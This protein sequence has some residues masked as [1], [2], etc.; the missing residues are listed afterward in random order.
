MV[1]HGS[2]LFT[3]VLFS[4]LSL[5]VVKALEVSDL[6]ETDLILQ[7]ITASIN[8][9]WST[10]INDEVWMCEEPCNATWEPVDGSL[11]Q[12]DA[13]DTEVWGID[14]GDTVYKAPIDGSAN[15]TLVPGEMKHI[16]AS[17]YGYI[18]AVGSGDLVHKCKKPCNGEWDTVE[19]GPQLRQL[20]GEYGLVYGVTRSGEVYSRPVDGSGSWRKIPGPNG[21]MM[22]Y[23][24]ASGREVI[25]GITEGGHIYRCIKPCVGEWEK[26]EGSAQQCDASVNDVYC[27]NL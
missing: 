19:D 27:I 9:L 21:E 22:K 15:F 20:D 3:L 10:T 2:K 14:S 13:S 6:N 18:W 17:G 24:T 4:I 1:W 8:Y 11:K 5:Y 12:L 7:H 25:T 23:V 16:S 26:V